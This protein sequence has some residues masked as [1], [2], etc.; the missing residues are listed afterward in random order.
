MSE[1]DFKQVL[2][3]VAQGLRLIHTQNL[4]HLDIKPGKPLGRR[5]ISSEWCNQVYGQSLFNKCIQTLLF[6]WNAVLFAGNIFIHRNEKFLRSPESGMESCEELDDDEVEETP[7][8]I[9]KIGMVIKFV[10][11]V[12]NVIS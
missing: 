12:L 1:S 3:Q 5:L 10:L 9:Y 11:R 6:W 7:A 8:I 4:V 2:L